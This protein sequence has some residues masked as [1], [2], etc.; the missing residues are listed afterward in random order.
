M[1]PEER[2]ELLAAYSLGSL[3][4]VEQSEVEALVRSDAKAAAD[5]AA[6]HE[7]V[8]VIA[9]SVPLRRA[10]PKLRDRVLAAA[11][12]EVQPVRFGGWPLQRMM[13]YGAAAAVLIV[14]FLWGMNLQQ[15]L[16]LLRG[17]NVRLTAIVEV[18][19]KRLEA[20]TAPDGQLANS[21]ALMLQL[22]QALA[23][24]QIVLAVSAD[25]GAKSSVLQPTP[26]GHGAG[27][28]YLWSSDLAA[29]VIVARNLPPLPL[30]EVYQVWLEGRTEAVS[31]GTFVPDLNGDVEAVVRPDTEIG[32]LR[33]LIATA[34]EGGSATMGSLIVLVG[35]VSR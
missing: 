34:P 8:D 12:R 15:D 14:A 4:G 33:I 29:G 35:I 16:E 13:T 11:R 27:G 31:G 21:G 1:T 25:A 9:L 26:A 5:L 19:A 22:E 10:D 32:P 3:S 20:L 17:E 28:H 7:L 30:G 2:Q 6:Y 24:Q 23:D 18:D